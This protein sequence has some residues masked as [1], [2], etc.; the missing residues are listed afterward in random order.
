MKSFKTKTIFSKSVLITAT[1]A[2]LFSCSD[3][4]EVSPETTWAVED[5]YSDESEVN[6]A[7]AGIYSSLRSNQTFGERILI[8]ESGTDE[9]YA[10]K[11]WRDYSPTS[12][13]RHDEATL[14]I[15]NAWRTF[16]TGINNI[17]QFLKNIKSSSFEDTQ[18]YN[19]YVGE[20]R[21]LRGFFYL[22]L[23]SWWNEVPLRLTPAV[24]QESNHIAPSS[25]EDVYLQIIEDLTFAVD[26]L[27]MANDADYVPGHANKMA[28]HAIL[29][30]TYLKAAGFPLRATEINNLNPYEAA[31]EHCKAIIDSGVHSLN[32]SYKDL[33]LGYI[34]NTFDLNESIF[35]IVFVNG[36]DLG[37]SIAGSIGTRNG[38]FYKP[39]DRINKPNS[40]PEITPTPIVE[41]MYEEGDARTSWNIPS[42][43]GRQNGSGVN[44]VAGS[45]TWGYSIGKF[46]RWDMAVP[47][48]IDATN[49]ADPSIIPL[50]PVTPLAINTTGINLP[51]VR[52]ADVLL[53][54]AEAVNELSGP[55]S[56]AIAAVDLVRNR[57]GLD[58]LA[59][60]K[61]DAIASNDA[62]FSEITD[63]RL[64]ELCFEGNRKFDLIRWGLLGDKILELEAAIKYHPDFNE[65]LNAHKGF[66][67]APDNFDPVKHLSLPYPQQEVAINNL[68]NQK[69][70]W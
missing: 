1:I 65:N 14:E 61:P 57:A 69:S 48:D 58:N 13:Y 63:E 6:I 47:G 37:V 39:N 70:E 49:A 52:Y 60:V 31:K 34:K 3:T 26:A 51:L 25:L 53:M 15:T 50:E 30:R 2:L 42:I 45:L 40:D 16:Y 46:R 36:S 28:A 23:T 5:F 35:E 11:A 9:S 29:A 56:E 22:Q 67:R 55:T 44:E 41:L 66:L 33:F 12:V 19:K 68:L 27:P 18:S 17:N 38:L 8:M 10:F 7:L 62:F 64:R 24:N 20:A 4:L 32:P 59:I 54:Y 21:F 43:L